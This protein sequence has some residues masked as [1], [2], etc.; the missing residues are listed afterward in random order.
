MPENPATSQSPE[1]GPVRRGPK[2]SVLVAGSFLVVAGCAAPAESRFLPDNTAAQ[3]PAELE[4]NT[5]I[6]LPAGS[7]LLSAARTTLSGGLESRT[8]AQI[9]MPA[10]TVGRF[11]T[12]SGFTAPTPGKR[13][14]SDSDV[15]GSGTWHPDKAG[16]VAGTSDARRRVMVENTTPDS[17]VYLVAVQN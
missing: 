5:G 16:D 12:D 13:T 4:A 8:F 1:P 7:L 2:W 3:S 6:R 14:V 9:R 15:P 17:T 10:T 11:L